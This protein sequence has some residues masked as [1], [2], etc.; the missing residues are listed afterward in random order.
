MTE[1]TVLLSPA[2]MA[3][4]RLSATELMNGFAREDGTREVLS[5]ED[6]GLCYMGRA[7]L[8]EATV[9]SLL[10]VCDQ[11]RSSRCKRPSDCEAV[12]VRLLNN[13]KHYEGTDD[14]KNQ[15]WYYYFKRFIER[16]DVDRRLCWPC[17]EKLCKRQK[18]IHYDT[19]QK[20]PELMGLSIEGWAEESSKEPSET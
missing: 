5:D 2:L 6:I 10:Q 11:T 15:R 14:I 7:A 13:V 12:F 1:T 17:W 16:W 9:L 8:T 3:C 19:W 4:C 18:Q 20:L